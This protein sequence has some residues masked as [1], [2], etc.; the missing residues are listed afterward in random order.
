[1]LTRRLVP[2]VAVAL[3]L[4]LAG[5]RPRE[6]T[7]TVDVART[8]AATETAGARRDAQATKRAPT[9]IA[10]TTAEAAGAAVAFE[11]VAAASS[12]DDLKREEVAAVISTASAQV[13]AWRR[14]CTSTGR[15]SR[16]CSGG[17]SLREV[18]TAVAFLDLI[19]TPPP[20]TWQR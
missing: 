16:W 15:N 11:T 10:E 5:C 12:R 2:G 4:A 8:G 19:G 9:A 1:M 18:Q 7:P 6:P 17:P 3:A 13:M 14:E 20:P